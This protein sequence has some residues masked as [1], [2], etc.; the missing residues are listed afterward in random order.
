M[1]PDDSHPLTPTPSTRSRRRYVNAAFERMSGYSSAECLGR[2]CRFLQ[3]PASEIDAVG[4]IREAM[5]QGK[6]AKIAL[7]NYKKDGTS[8]VNLLALKPVFHV[9]AQDAE[10]PESVATSSTTT[11]TQR[12]RHEAAAVGASSRT[13]VLRFFV[14]VQYEA[15]TASMVPTRLLQLDALIKLLPETTSE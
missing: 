15:A 7:T 8:F 2:N 14:G 6:V 3:G 10:A 13:R 12:T 5:Q 4:L 11:T 1:A 9:P